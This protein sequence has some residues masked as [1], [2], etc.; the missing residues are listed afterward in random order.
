MCRGN[1]EVS[2]RKKASHCRLVLQLNEKS[3]LQNH[4]G[5]SL[6]FITRHRAK[7]CASA[8]MTS[9]IFLFIAAFI[10]SIKEKSFLLS[11]SIKWNKPVILSKKEQLMIRRQKSQFYTIRYS[12]HM[13]VRDDHA[14]LSDDH[15]FLSDDHAFLSDDHV[16]LSDDHAF[17]SNDHAFLHDDHAFLHDD[18]AFLSDD[19]AFLSD[20]HAFLSDDHAFLSD[21]HAFLRDDHAFVRDDYAFLSDDLP[22]EKRV[23]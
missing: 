6:S 18:H 8:V 3:P 7:T 21:D 10:L 16:F 23:C 9:P 2:N 17:L 13:F 11:T 1:N 22:L 15:V 20:D 12:D 19:H 4:L 14:F 5:G